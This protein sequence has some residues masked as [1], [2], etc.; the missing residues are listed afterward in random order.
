MNAK[1]AEAKRI[2]ESSLWQE[3]IA[4]TQERLKAEWSSEASSARRELLWHKYQALREPEIELRRIADAG[5]IED[6]HLR[7]SHLKEAS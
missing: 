5:V 7:R 1:S 4:S 2:L 3:V 6:H